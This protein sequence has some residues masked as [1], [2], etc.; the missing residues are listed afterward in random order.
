M[1]HYTASV[2]SAV[3][4][5]ALIGSAGQGKIASAA[6]AEFVDAAVVVLT[7]LGYDGKSD[8]LA[9]DSAYTVAELVAEISLQT[10]KNPPCKDLPA[11]ADAAA[12][13]GAVATAPWP[14]CWLRLM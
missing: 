3:A 14:K 4:N 10:S 6:W 7:P 1:E 11:A 5:G 2:R 9:G 12:L 8:E 13:A